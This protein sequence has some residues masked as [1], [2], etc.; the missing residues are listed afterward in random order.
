MSREIVMTMELRVWKLTGT[1]GGGHSIGVSIEDCIE[2]HGWR[3]L[4]QKVTFSHTMSRKQPRALPDPGPTSVLCGSMFRAPGIASLTSKHDKYI[5][6]TNQSGQR[7]GLFFNQENI[8]PWDFSLSFLHEQV[9]SFTSSFKTFVEFKY[10][11]P[12]TMKS[13]IQQKHNTD[14]GDNGY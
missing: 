3:P 6:S 11:K 8:F 1:E 12:R 7:P 5:P 4:P 10:F 2:E 9:P 14:E 13:Q